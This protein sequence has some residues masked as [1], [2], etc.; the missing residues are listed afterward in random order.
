[1]PHCLPRRDRAWQRWPG[2]VGRW[3]RISR[4]PPWHE[5]RWHF[6]NF[7]RAW[8]P[9]EPVRDNPVAIETSDVWS[10]QIFGVGLERGFFFLLFDCLGGSGLVCVCVMCVSD[11]L[12]SFYVSGM[13]SLSLC[14]CT[15]ACRGHWIPEIGVTGV[16][17]SPCRCWEPSS[18][19][20]QE[21]ARDY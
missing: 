20:L 5:Q 15:S 1:M 14:V 7:S 18:G 4:L 16:C 13:F 2:P 11:S 3:P 9:G 8:R 10:R 6:L 19:P 17:E 12:F 21:M